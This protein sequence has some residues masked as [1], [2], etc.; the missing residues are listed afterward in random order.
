[1]RSPG[2]RQLFLNLTGRV[3]RAEAA[4]FWRARP[5]F[6]LKT[7]CR[8]RTIGEPRCCR[9]VATKGCFVPRRKAMPRRFIP[10]DACP[11]PTAVAVRFMTRIGRSENLAGPS[12]I[13][14]G[15]LFPAEQRRP[16]ISGNDLDAGDG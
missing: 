5:G 7:G 3:V 13:S 10:I 14:C 16:I 6:N 12:I 4:G 8:A 11:R 2:C 15:R 9:I 1:V